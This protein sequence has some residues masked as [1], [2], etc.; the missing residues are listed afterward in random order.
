SS[1]A[2]E[3]AAGTTNVIGLIMNKELQIFRCVRKLRGRVFVFVEAGSII[4]SL[5]LSLAKD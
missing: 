2:E 3:K 4:L 1:Q 5:P